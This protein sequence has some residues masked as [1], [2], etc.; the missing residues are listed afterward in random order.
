[1]T[2]TSKDKALQH[3][4]VT[5][6]PNCI[7]PWEGRVSDDGWEQL[8]HGVTQPSVAPHGDKSRLE[9]FN[10]GQFDNGYRALKNHQHSTALLIDYDSGSAGGNLTLTKGELQACW[11]RWTFLAH[12]TISHR[13][14]AARW[15]VAIPFDKPITKEEY[16][17]TLS[18]AGHVGQPVLHL[19]L[20][21]R[22]QWR[23]RRQVGGLPTSRALY[24]GVLRRADSH[25]KPL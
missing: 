1:M 23:L 2:T 3:V 24:D 13:P 5:Y 6:W 14:E 9:V 21:L 12:T 10:F 17:P 16:G 15:R 7:Q 18:C 11:G 8:V 20:W 19:S 25:S 22:L 4:V